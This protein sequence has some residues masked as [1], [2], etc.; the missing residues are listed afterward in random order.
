MS[1]LTEIK[2]AF[3]NSSIPWFIATETWLF[4]TSNTVPH[5]SS[6]ERKIERSKE[7]VPGAGW[8]RNVFS[9][10]PSESVEFSIKLVAI[11]EELGVT[12]QTKFFEMLT[13]PHKTAYTNL[14]ALDVEPFYPPAKVL[15]YYGLGKSP[16]WYDVDSVSIT[17]TNP[18]RL[19]F[20][21]ECEIRVGMTEDRDGTM[22]KME[23]GLAYAMANL[24]T[25]VAG[26]DFASN[27]VSSADRIT[28][29]YVA[30]TLSSLKRIMKR[31][32]G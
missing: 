19:G 17:P 7:P 27:F 32:T 3:K 25:A 10:T 13:V 26:V 4:L 23:V 30:D 29:P 14:S 31:A 20:P 1:K 28:N 5:S 16:M 15:Y 24:M 9:N 21:R 8:S 22:Y 18:N 2:S 11:N 12:P 6:R